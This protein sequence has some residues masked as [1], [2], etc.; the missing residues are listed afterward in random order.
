MLKGSGFLHHV[1]SFDFGTSTPLPLL[2]GLQLQS[3]TLGL[4]CL[5]L[6]LQNLNPEAHSTFFASHV[7]THIG[8]GKHGPFT[9]SVRFYAPDIRCA[10]LVQE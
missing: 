1:L 9:F 3:L 8:P 5:H 10:K 7:A 6:G 2:I 4:F